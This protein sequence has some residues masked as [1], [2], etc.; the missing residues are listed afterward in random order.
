M[1]T[2]SAA[3]RKEKPMNPT[4]RI[5]AAVLGCTGLVGRQFIR[6]LD[7]H[8]YFELVALSSSPRSAGKVYS[9]AVSEEAGPPIPEVVRLMVVREGTVEA[10]MRSGARVVFSALPASAAAVVEPELRRQGL[11]VFSNASSR[12]MDT[13]VPLL[14][15]EVNPDHLELARD[16]VRRCGAAIITNSNCSTAGLVMVLKPLQDLGLR[17]VT[18]S[19]YQAVSGAGRRGLAAMDIAANVIPFI[20]D[21]E[22]KLIRETAKILGRL[23]FGRVEP[24]GPE[25]NASC[26]RVPVREGHL[27]GLRLDFVTDI[28]LRDAEAALADFRGRPQERGL[29]SA[30]ERPVIVR[31]EEDRPQPVLDAWAGWPARARGMAVSVGRLRKRGRSM[32]CFALVHNLVRGAAGSCLLGAELALS[33]GYFD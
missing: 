13:D 8:P 7:A 9:R 26:C 23:E 6:M 28:E 30:P 31:S 5:K 27:L 33:Q 29:P 10:V 14:I 20:R 21:E 24:G 3:A 12:R 16:Q 1:S 32:G 15:P 18:V 22:E 11:F 2:R 4:P 19:T 17:S 25:V